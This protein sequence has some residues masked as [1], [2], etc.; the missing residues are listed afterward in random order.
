MKLFLLFLI[1][2]LPSDIDQLLQHKSSFRRLSAIKL[3]EKQLDENPE[4][5]VKKLTIHRDDK[6]VKVRKKIAEV[7]GKSQLPKAE[8]V[9]RIFKE[10]ETN[11]VVLKEIDKA[12]KLIGPIPDKVKKEREIWE[13]RVEIAI[14]ANKKIKQDAFAHVL[15]FR[16]SFDDSK[17]AY[18]YAFKTLKELPE[19]YRAYKAT[20]KKKYVLPLRNNIPAPVLSNIMWMLEGGM[21]DVYIILEESKEITTIE[22]AW[23]EILRL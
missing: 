17:V 14:E 2:L 5:V 20:G 9:L 11:K 3:L 22:K 12:I 13:K 23:Y 18:D 19:R 16:P 4:Y 15:K 10:E 8:K 21:G 7:L 6:S 1:L